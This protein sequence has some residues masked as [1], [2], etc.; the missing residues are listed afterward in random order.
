MMAIPFHWFFG[1]HDTNPYGL[2]HKVFGETVCEKANTA[3]NRAKKWCSQNGH[4]LV[5][6]DATTAVA[7]HNA[8]EGLYTLRL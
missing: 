3:Y 7:H 6:F 5:Y 1:L 4:E 8:N 2:P